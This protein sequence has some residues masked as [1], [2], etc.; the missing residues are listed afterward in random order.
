MGSK[1]ANA[2]IPSIDDLLGQFRGLTDP[3]AIGRIDKE[4]EALEARLKELRDFKA[5]ITGQSLSGN[6]P[7]KGRKIPAKYVNPKNQA[8]TWA[9][10]GMYPKW[11]DRELKAG[12]KLEDFAVR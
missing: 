5:L 6:N 9:G 10:R 8:E 4:M 7:Q 11:L 3:N 12:K 2:K 1:S